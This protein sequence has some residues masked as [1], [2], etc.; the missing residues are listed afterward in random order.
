MS[1]KY[2]MSNKTCGCCQATAASIPEEIRNRPG[3]SAVHYRVGTYAGFRQAMIQ[4]IAGKPAL[5]RWTARTSDDYGIA[6]VEMWAYLADILTFYQERIANEAFL[7]TALLQTS[8]RRLAGFLDYRPAPGKASAA[9]LAFILEKGKNLR[10]PVGLRVQSVPGQNETP[11]K[12]ET[13][14]AATAAA[15]LNRVRVFPKP[16]TANPFDAASEKAILKPSVANAVIGILSPGDAL[17]FFD[18]KTVVPKEVVSAQIDSRGHSSLAWKPKMQHKLKSARAFKRV[19]TMRFF[20]HNAPAQYVCTTPDNQCPNGV[21]TELIERK[22]KDYHIKLK[23]GDPFGL[24]SVYEA[25]KPGTRLLLHAEGSFTGI[26][27]VEAA[28]QGAAAFDPASTA[29][30]PF[31]GTATLISVAGKLPAKS[32]DRRTAVLYEL[33]EPEIEFWELAFQNTSIQ[34]NDPVLIKAEDV[35][36][37]DFTKGRTVML[38][39]DDDTA[40]TATVESAAEATYGGTAFVKITFKSPLRSTFDATATVLYG[41]VVRATHGET[42]TKEVLGNG[43]ASAAFQTFI[44]KKSPVTFVPHAAA[45]KGAASTLDIRVDSVLWEEKDALYGCDGTERIYTTLV[46]EEGVMTVQFGDGKTGARLTTGRQNVSAT[47]RHGL[48]QAGNVNAN[49]LTTLLDRPIGLRRVTNPAPAQGGVEPETLQKTRT[50]APNT[51][52]TFGRIV[53]LR[54]VEDAAREFTGIAKARAVWTRQGPEQAVRLTV[55]GDRGA[56]VKGPLMGQF[57]AY[58]DQRRDPNRELRIESYRKIPVKA[59][60][61]IECNP[62][63]LTENVKKAVQKAL[64]EYFAFENLALGQPIHLSDL[65]RLLQHVTGVVAVDI[66]GLQFKDKTDRKPH[67]ATD[68]PVQERLLLTP[69]EL[70]FIKNPVSDAVVTV[71]KVAS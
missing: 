32:F 31:T 2:E 39:D 23:A 18:K 59:D 27:T 44:L 40:E 6:L 51:I 14:A 58:L 5:R 1:I 54:D 4:A 20:G 30:D 12:F 22:A 53:S 62:A 52:R 28:S 69:A 21:K 37:G 17:L 63:Y 26:V 49:A 71:G 70:A 3:L 64:R 68:A 61:Q 36:I 25:L 45:R 57:R 15:R 13:V 66:N 7:R 50:N 29:Y 48:G 33:A 9:D 10:I 34:K 35:A 42:V 19:R 60:V 43:D 47:Y 56:E 11:Q 38:A 67:G 41:N 46:D 16:E 55:A 8:V 24:D 65:Y